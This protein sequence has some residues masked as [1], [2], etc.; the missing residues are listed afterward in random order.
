MKRIVASLSLMLALPMMAIVQNG[1]PTT[2][3]F[4]HVNSQGTVC[5]TFLRELSS[6]TPHILIGDV[7][8][9]MNDKKTVPANYPALGE[10]I[11]GNG[12]RTM[13]YLRLEIERFVSGKVHLTAEQNALAFWMI[14]MGE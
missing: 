5:R 8:T 14:G 12:I 4:F 13:D 2:G 9:R 11:Q 6:S 1:Y 3:E 7:V 10:I